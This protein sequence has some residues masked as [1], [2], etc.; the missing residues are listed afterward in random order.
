MIPWCWDPVTGSR[1]ALQF[2]TGTSTLDVSLK[3]AQSLL[4]VF[5]PDLA[6]TPPAA[7]VIRQDDYMPINTPWDLTLNSVSDAGANHTVTYD[8]YFGTDYTAVSS[9]Y[10]LAFDFNGDGVVNWL[11]LVSVSQ[12]WLSSSDAFDLN[13]DGCVNL[14]DFADFAAQFGLQAPPE[15]RCNQASAV[16][17]PGTCAPNSTY[18]WRVDKVTGTAVY[19]GPVWNFITG[20]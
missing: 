8:V 9:A 17:K 4:V 3:P 5:E 16:F 15:F 14:L 7:P 13:R 18:Y 20:P 1:H 12:Q 6:D 11:D 19:K 10:R 2:S